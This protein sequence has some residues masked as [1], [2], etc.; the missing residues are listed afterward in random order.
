MYSTSGTDPSSRPSTFKNVNVVVP[1]AVVGATYL[2]WDS[3]TGHTG[4]ESNKSEGELHDG[5]MISSLVK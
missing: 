1:R 5:S 2:G 4:D 3:R